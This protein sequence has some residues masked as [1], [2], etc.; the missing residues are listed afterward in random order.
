MIF[1]TALLLATAPVRNAH[2]SSQKSR[3]KSHPPTR[4]HRRPANS[5][6]PRKASRHA[7]RAVDTRPATGEVAF[8]RSFS[9]ATGARLARWPGRRIRAVRIAECPGEYTVLMV[10][11]RQGADVPRHPAR[12]VL[13]RSAGE[14]WAVPDVSPGQVPS[15][16]RRRL[17]FVFDLC[18]P[19]RIRTCEHGSGVQS[20][21][22]PLPAETRSELQARGAYGAR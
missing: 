1:R 2:A 5:S 20:R 22:Q 10:V 9:A 6:M 8:S 17:A 3:W 4:T 7:G 19:S 18:A 16:Q 13:G 12:S 15:P 11:D 21:I 14:R